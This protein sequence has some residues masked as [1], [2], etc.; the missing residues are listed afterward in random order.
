MYVDA[1]RFCG[2]CYRFQ[3]PRTFADRQLSTARNSLANARRDRRELKLRDFPKC[4]ECIAPQVL[5]LKCSACRNRFS[6]RFFS[7]AMRA[8]PHGA[9]IEADPFAALSSD[10]EL[11]PF[12]LDDDD[13][14]SCSSAHGGSSRS[15][16]KGAVLAA[17][18]HGQVEGRT[19][20]L[21][22]AY[23]VRRG[24]KVVEEREFGLEAAGDE[25][26]RAAQPAVVYDEDD[27]DW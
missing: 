21:D 9:T 19:A 22:E 10:E 23:G 13:L 2:S 7:E 1:C 12:D 25:K 26:P 15:S 6:V 11:D 16:Y 17:G 18:Q 27:E 8:N 4:D 14:T 20:G 24:E 3:P 5:K